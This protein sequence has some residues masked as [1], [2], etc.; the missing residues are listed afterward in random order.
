MTIGENPRHG[1]HND[2]AI[3]LL[4][5]REVRRKQRLAG[6]PEAASQLTTGQ[7]I[8]DYVAATMGSWRFIIIQTTILIAWIALNVTAYVQRW[9]SFS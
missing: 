5:L 9:G 8:A 1:L 6:P 7:R 2:E 4:Q 3:L